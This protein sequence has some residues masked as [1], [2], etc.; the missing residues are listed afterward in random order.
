[1]LPFISMVFALSLLANIFYIRPNSSIFVVIVA[2]DIDVVAVVLIFLLS[3]N[4]C[5]QT[6]S[7]WTIH[8]MLIYK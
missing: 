7:F 6:K 2:V 5:L 3:F 1:M 4:V 8:W